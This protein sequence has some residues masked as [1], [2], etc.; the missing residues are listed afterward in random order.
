AEEKMN[1]PPTKT[2]K[3]SIMFTYL[4][5]MAGYKHNQLKNKSFDDIQKLFDK[6]MKRVNIFVDMDTELVEEN[7]KRAEGIETR[8][9]GSS[10]R[11]GDKLEQERIK[12][13]KMDEN[14]ET[15]KL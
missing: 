4:K 10:Q 9:K 12:K 13:Q 6:E 5:N 15:T 1:I 3:R 2:Q 7:T 8:A 14:K 11:A